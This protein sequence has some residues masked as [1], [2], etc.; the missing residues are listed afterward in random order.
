MNFINFIEKKNHLIL[1]VFKAAGLK[2]KNSKEKQSYFSNKMY[3][4]GSEGPKPNIK[5]DG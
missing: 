4:V 5:I 2:K 1:V 3:V